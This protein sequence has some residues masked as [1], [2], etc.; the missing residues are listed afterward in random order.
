VR[1]AIAH[2]VRK[3]REATGRR[4]EVLFILFT[5]LL[6]LLSGDDSAR[7]KKCDGPLSSF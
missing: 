3:A 1:A 7:G 5:V 4:R 2:R 6:S